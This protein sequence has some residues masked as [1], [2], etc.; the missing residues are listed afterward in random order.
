MNNDGP[1]LI[2]TDEGPTLLYRGRYLYNRR[3]PVSSVLRRIDNVSFSDKTLIIIPSPL[4]FYGVN[5]LLNSLSGQ[6]HL[7]CVEPETELMNL[8]LQ[9]IPQH[10]IHQDSFSY[11]RSSD[12]PQIIRFIENLGLWRFRLV[13]LLP[14][15]GGYSLNSSFFSDLEKKTGQLI[16]SY[17]QNRI[18]SIHMGTRWNSNLLANL[19]YCNRFFFN[20]CIPVTDKPVCVAGAGES[21]ELSIEMIREVREELYVLA[22]DTAL[23]A[24]SR[25]G[26]APDG[27]CIV[28]SQHVNLFD[29]IGA[30]PEQAD[31]FIDATAHP[32]HFRLFPEKNYSLFCSAY[33]RNRLLDRLRTAG[34]VPETIPPLGSVGIVALYIALLYTS[35]PVFFTGLDFS[36]TPGKP[37]SRG[38]PSHTLIL[39]RTNRFLPPH[40][41]TE[42]LKRSQRRCA[43]QKREYQ[44]HKRYCFSR[45]QGILHVS[46]CGSRQSI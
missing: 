1:R 45:L 41:L 37:H 27:I 34:I 35:G 22:V 20:T 46:P 32:A 14:L 13:R 18:T 19:V 38:T 7:L 6:Y 8:S 5:E 31:I 36:Y 10:N 4:L 26:I 12:L 30:L 40:A 17:W 44:R 29:F 3:S 39:T 24:L 11:I 42:S 33:G 15:N 28:E 43:G 21:L 16:S 23:P 2:E 9:F 25:F